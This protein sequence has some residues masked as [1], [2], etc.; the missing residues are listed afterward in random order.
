MP[1]DASVWLAS[2]WPTEPAH[3]D[4]DLA[5]DAARVLLAWP[6][7]VMHELDH[8]T[9]ADATNVT[10]TCALRGADAIYV[11][12]AGWSRYGRTEAFGA[13]FIISSITEYVGVDIITAR[14]HQ[15]R[16]VG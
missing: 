3:R 9:A 5:L 15:S 13:W 10:A 16:R 6:T 12:T 7:L 4:R 14:W 1:L 8:S 2:L 11:A